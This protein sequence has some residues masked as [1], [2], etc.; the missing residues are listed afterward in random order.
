MKIL[1]VNC[2]SSSL[3]YQLIEMENEEVL[4]SGKCDRIGVKGIE[5]P[6]IEYKGKDG[7]KL[8]KELELPN[9][10]VA[11]EEV[12]KYLLDPEVGAIKDLSEINGIGHRIVNGGPKLAQSMLIT[13][14][15][16]EEYTKAIE[17]APLHNPA[18]IQGIEACTKIM[19][20]IPQVLV[21]DTS[22]HT[23]I[24]EKAALYAIPYEYYEK[25]GIKRYGAH[26]TS[27]K[28]ITKQAAKVLG[29]DINDINIISCHLGNG[30]SIAAVKNGKCVDTTMGLTPLEGLVMG[31]RSGDLD[32]AVLEFVM[33]KE[34]L[35]IDEMM[36]I[37]N[38]K[39][40]LL[41][42]SGITGDIRDLK[43][44]IAEGNEKAALA[45]D[46]FAY[47][48]RKYIGAYMAVLGRVDAIIFEGGIGEHNPD[49][50]S[51]ALEGLEELGIKYDNSHN[52][53]EMYEGIVSM[54]D[55]KIKMYIIP[56]NE[57]LEIANETMEIVK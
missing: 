55:S 26:G 30:A 17:Y 32:P 57:E 24:P 40:G 33:K 44:L 22:F 54:P 47:R 25:Y 23:T 37:L 11:F 18:H 39:S 7:K 5:S 51:K 46:M 31:T 52:A 14:E 2:G 48:V 10:T 28:Y 29:K 45:V 13:D 42:I 1:V 36:T 4:A 38:K 12:V 16:M 21:F 53:D 34:N 6:F 3:K 15:V 8:K 27:H 50:I 49:V 41:G 20:G 19:P 43:G 56:T 9:H 35:T